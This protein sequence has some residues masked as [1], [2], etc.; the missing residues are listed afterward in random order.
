MPQLETRISC[1]IHAQ[2]Q[3]L[4]RLMRNHTGERQVSG[5]CGKTFYSVYIL[6]TSFTLY[7]ISY[8]ESR[9][10]VTFITR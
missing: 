5:I 1:I 10:E 7:D 4:K 6:F 8:S 9:I 2:L 3:V